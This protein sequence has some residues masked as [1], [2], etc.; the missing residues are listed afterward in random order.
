MLKRTCTC[1]DLRKDQAGET[2]LLSGWVN[3]YRD[4]RKSLVFIDLRDRYG[5]TQVVFDGED[6]PEEVMELGSSLRREDVIS[7]EGIVRLRDGKPNAKLETGEIE[8][9]A[10]KIEVINRTAKL[11]ILPDDHDADK[12]GE[13][14]RLRYRYIDLRRPRMQ[15]IL[16]LRHKITQFTRNFFTDNG[17][18]EIETPLLITPTPEGARDFIVP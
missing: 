14:H 1:G 13:E 5:M 3:T 18:L 2:I 15:K 10:Q 16:A 7:V 8:L 6:T 4:Q 12:I 11:P 9:V 17:F